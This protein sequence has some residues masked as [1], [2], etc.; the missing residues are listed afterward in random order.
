MC[1]P[2]VS[3][4]A[5]ADA[6]PE[7]LWFCVTIPDHLGHVSRD[8]GLD[9]CSLCTACAQLVHACDQA[10]LFLQSLVLETVTKK[11]FLTATTKEPLAYGVW[12]RV[13]RYQSRE[14]IDAGMCVRQAAGNGMESL[15]PY[16]F[17]NYKALNLPNNH[18]RAVSYHC[19][20]LSTIQH[21]GHTCMQA[22]IPL[23][24]TS[25]E[26]RNGNGN[27]KQPI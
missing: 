2:V 17:L 21:K 24:P 13:V 3:P 14:S 25:F 12:G 26:Y 7:S 11:T 8:T 5:E 4:S 22:F 19:E 10:S 27:R 1:R 16:F 18:E 20:R 23:Q 15:L 9:H 6:R